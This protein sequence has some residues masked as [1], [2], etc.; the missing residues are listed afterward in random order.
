MNCDANIGT[1]SLNEAPP[2]CSAEFARDLLHRTYGID[3]QANQLA[4]ERDQIFT[5][6]TESDAGFVLRL[7]NPAEDRQVTNFQTEAM[8]HLNKQ[9]PELP[10]P[11]V[12]PGE[13]GDAEIEVSLPDGRPSIARLITLLPGV[14]L[15]TVPERNPGVRAS[16]ADHIA[17]MGFAFR[18]FFHPAANHELLWDMKHA[19]KLRRFLPY[20]MRRQIQMQ[21]SFPII[22][23]CRLHL[24]PTP[25]LRV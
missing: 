7:T 16:M 11:R 6:K 24:S 20:L 17:K 25:D 21:Q 3:G 22:I 14:A 15:A 19:L 13:N 5:V 23:R 2:N 18:G 8:V 9:A 1:D 4:C 10:V 12:V